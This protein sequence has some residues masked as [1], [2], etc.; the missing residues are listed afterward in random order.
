MRGSWQ[1]CVCS[2][3][4]EKT[5]VTC[6]PGTGTHSPGQRPAEPTLPP[7]GMLLRW[8]RAA[9][10]CVAQRTVCCWCG[11]AGAVVVQ[12]LVQRRLRVVAVAYQL[13][14]HP[15][16]VGAGARVRQQLPGRQQLLQGL[17]MLLGGLPGEGQGI[18]ADDRQGLRATTR[19]KGGRDGAHAVRT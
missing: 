10:R 14:E 19:M 16:H 3:S 15:Q 12:Q 5:I 9:L 11:A 6:T 13:E 1:A 2:C 8:R 7:S 18:E 4:C 17:L